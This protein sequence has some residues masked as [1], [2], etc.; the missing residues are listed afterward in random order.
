MWA[1]VP[2]DDVKEFHVIE[3]NLQAEREAKV[4]AAFGCSC[5]H[6]QSSQQQLASRPVQW[7]TAHSVPFPVAICIPVQRPACGGGRAR[8]APPPQHPAPACSRACNVQVA[9]L[10][11]RKLALQRLGN[12]IDEAEALGGHPR[13]LSPVSTS[14]A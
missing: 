3:D 13:R 4:W 8:W 9:D 5:A 1:T 14:A 7:C 2:E 12:H 6:S 10:I 11:Q